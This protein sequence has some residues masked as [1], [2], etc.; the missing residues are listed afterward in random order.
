MAYVFSTISR[1][2]YGHGASSEIG[3]EVKR[4]GC[5]R[6]Y[7]VMDQGILDSRVHAPVMESLTA[8]GI[9]V[10][11]YSGVELDPSP[12]CVEAAL[13]GLQ[14][15]NADIIIGVGGGSSLD[16]AK[17]LAILAK[18]PGPLERYFGM[19]LV[20]GPCMPMILVPTASG[21][22]SETTSISVLADAASNSKKGIVSDYIYAK[23][24]VLD[25]DLTMTLSP[26]YTAYTG[27]DAFVHAMESYVNL[28]ATPFTEGPDLQA[29]E[30]IAAN[31]RKAYTNGRNK[32]ARAQM[33]YAASIAGMGFSNTQNGVIHAL[34]M[35]APAHY[36]LP[37]GLLMAAIAPMGIA[38]NCIAAPEKYARVAKILGCATDGLDVNE[39]ARMAVHGF[40]RLLKDVNV[41][42]GLEPYGIKREDLRGI[43]ERAAAS[44]RLMGNNP[45]Q[46]TA[47]DLET[48]L[49]EYY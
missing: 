31:L 27:L 7:L 40:E 17:A 26:L 1:T 24:I 37:H 35:A 18:H 34:G 42:P 48:L 13:P 28:S 2:V 43:A 25:P 5:N 49:Q 6:A 47:D 8:A 21:T 4:L 15:F 30:M 36:H 20:P 38:F 29:M 39:Q 16:A 19:H 14:A 46:G 3:G 11:V 41:K 12:A 9:A 45:R 10:E 33:L 23:T 44:A 22:G 32:E